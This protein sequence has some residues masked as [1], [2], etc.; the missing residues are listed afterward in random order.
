MPFLAR[1]SEAE[2]AMVVYQ[3]PHRGF[4]RGG[5]PRKALPKP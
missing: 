5:G 2:E 4:C 1:R 3:V